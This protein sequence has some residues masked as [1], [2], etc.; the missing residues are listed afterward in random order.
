MKGTIQHN[1][2]TGRTI[3]FEDTKPL[4]IITNDI[5]RNREN[6]RNTRSRLSK[7]ER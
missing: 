2:E 4:A 1:S 6:I 3:K 7:H 5:I